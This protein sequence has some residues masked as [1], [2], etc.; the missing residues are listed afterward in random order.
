MVGIP[1]RL[2]ALLL[3][4]AFA[5]GGPGLPDLDA[6]LF[7]SHP[8]VVR[9]NVAHVDVPGGCG[10]HVER[11]VLSATLCGPQLVE[12]GLLKVRGTRVV[13][14]PTTF[15]LSSALRSSDRNFLYS[16]RAPPAPAC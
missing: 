3:L 12:L 15:R 14:R 4:V 5:G 9:A 10:A 16:S 7:H 13:S 2:G 6:L 1:R 11:C 8:D